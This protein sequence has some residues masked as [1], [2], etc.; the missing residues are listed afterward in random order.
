MAASLFTHCPEKPRRDTL[1]S[2]GSLQ[3]LCSVGPVLQ[4]HCQI[5]L[6]EEISQS[7]PR[8]RPAPAQIHNAWLSLVG[9]VESL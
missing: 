4:S 8:P 7:T 6:G 5:S 2:S 1:L 3:Q 9:A